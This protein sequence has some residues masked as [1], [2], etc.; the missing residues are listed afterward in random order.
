MLL[1][2]LEVNVNRK[3]RLTAELTEPYGPEDYVG[4]VNEWARA[5]GKK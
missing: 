5:H 4:V 1:S 3:N 2:D